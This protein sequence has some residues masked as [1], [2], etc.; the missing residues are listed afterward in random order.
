[1]NQVK[2]IKE[3]LLGVFKS[4]KDKIR[5]V[6]KNKITIPEITRSLN[7]VDEITKSII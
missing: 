7:S 4:F 1:M 5:P 3:I 2:R 6:L